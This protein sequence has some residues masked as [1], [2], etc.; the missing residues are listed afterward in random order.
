MLTKLGLHEGPLHSRSSWDPR[1][2]G[3]VL[4]STQLPCGLH[5]GTPTSPGLTWPQ[6]AV[7]AVQAMMLSP[8]WIL[9]SKCECALHSALPPWLCLRLD[10]PV[11]P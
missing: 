4:P 8:R 1:A 7:S 3:R 10:L 6:P 2:P 9:Q 11:A 5:R